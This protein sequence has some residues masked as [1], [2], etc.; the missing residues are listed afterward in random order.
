MLL[1]GFALIVSNSFF[2]WQNGVQRWKGLLASF[3]R[4]PELYQKL[5]QGSVLGYSLLTSS[6]LHQQSWP[7]GL[8]SHQPCLHFI[9]LPGLSSQQCY[10]LQKQQRM[11]FCCSASLWR[12]LIA[13]T[14][15][16]L[17]L[18]KGIFHSEWIW[19]NGPV[20]LSMVGYARLVPPVFI[21]LNKVQKKMSSRLLGWFL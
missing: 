21:A 6:M 10:L 5:D 9:L 15:V 3:E 19:L 18:C 17:Y 12:H 2:E 20:S 8:H 11:V 1:R 7:K 13:D 4:N 14:Q 16:S